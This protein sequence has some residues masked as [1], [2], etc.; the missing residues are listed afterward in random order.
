MIRGEALGDASLAL[1]GGSAHVLLKRLL[2]GI[3]GGQLT[4][5]GSVTLPRQVV[6][7]AL[8]WQG[9]GLD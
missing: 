6:D 9:V 7:V 3:G 1:E 8:A 4:A 5:Q 2:V